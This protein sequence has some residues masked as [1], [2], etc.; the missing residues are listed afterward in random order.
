MAGH[1]LTAA[2]EECIRYEIRLP[3]FDWSIIM[4]GPRSCY[5]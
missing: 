1:S 3:A 4:I 5:Q 2:R